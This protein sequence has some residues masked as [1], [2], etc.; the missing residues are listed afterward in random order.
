M[1][2]DPSS[3]GERVN[4]D[5]ATCLPH[6][7]LDSHPCTASPPMLSALLAAKLALPP[8]PWSRGVGPWA[9]RAGH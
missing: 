1:E 8:Q 6:P 5:S 7:W 3:L 2:E 9:N 4:S